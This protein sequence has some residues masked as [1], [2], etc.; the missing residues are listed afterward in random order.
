M[1][2]YYVTNE[3]S[4]IL[5]LLLLIDILSEEYR[6]GSFFYVHSVLTYPSLLFNKDFNF[7]FSTISYHANLHAHVI[8]SFTSKMITYHYYY[9]TYPISCS[10]DA[11]DSTLPTIGVA[12]LPTLL[13][14]AVGLSSDL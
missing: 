11:S 8:R 10:C 12:V 14:L 1:E 7:P 4:D 13:T 9:L 5:P 3:R 2:D 6:S